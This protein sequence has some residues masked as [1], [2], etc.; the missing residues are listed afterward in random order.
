MFFGDWSPN[1][2][3]A[4]YSDDISGAS[5]LTK[6]LVLDGHRDIWFIGDVELPWYNPC[7]QGYT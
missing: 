1:E 4:V 6:Q 2:C 7:A 5:A 3:D